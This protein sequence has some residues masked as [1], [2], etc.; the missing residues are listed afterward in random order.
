MVKYIYNYKRRKIFIRR[1]MRKSYSITYVND[2][3]NGYEN[4][5]YFNLDNNI[6]MYIVNKHKFYL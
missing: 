5:N 2:K 3:L 4:D 6:T 1:N